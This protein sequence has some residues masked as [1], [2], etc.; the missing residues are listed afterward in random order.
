MRLKTQVKIKS[1]YQGTTKFDF[2]KKLE[3]GTIVEISMVLEPTGSNR[4]INYT[5]I[6]TA[7]YGKSM[8]TF[9]DT[10]NSF[11]KYLN[12]IDYETY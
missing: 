6:I 1:K 11:L 9:S 5:P 2:W 8:E 10:I 7:T 4:G 12:K 3:P